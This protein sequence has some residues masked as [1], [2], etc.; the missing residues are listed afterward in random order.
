[1]ADDGEGDTVLLFEDDPATARLIPIIL[2]V[3]GIAVDV[4]MTYKGPADFAER[5]P[6]DLTLIDLPLDYRAGLEILAAGRR[7]WNRPVVLLSEPRP[8]DHLVECLAAGAFDIILKPFS[9]RTWNIASSSPS[10]APPNAIAAVPCA[11]P[12]WRSISPATAS[13]ATAN[14]RS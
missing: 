9:R 5:E 12:V 3:Q 6:P 7:A 11:S 8:E 14:R 2:R 4:V 10:G 1:M 13:L